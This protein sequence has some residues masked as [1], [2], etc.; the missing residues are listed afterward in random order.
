MNATAVASDPPSGSFSLEKAPPKVARRILCVEDND[1]DFGLFQ[2]HLKDSDLHPPPALQ[3]ARTLGEATSLIEKGQA[4]GNPFELV[5]LDL[6]LPDSAGEDTYFRVREQAP[7]A[8]IIVL[9]GMSDRGLALEM[10]QHGAQ[11]YV[12]KDALNGDL[13]GRSILYALERQRVKEGLVKLNEKLLQTTNDLKAAQDHL[14]QVEKLESL[15]RLA[16][17][18]AHEVKNPLGIIQMGVDYLKNKVGSLGPNAVT[19]LEHMEQAVTRADRIIWDMLDFSRSDSL[20]L[21]PCDANELAA[22]TLRMVN[23]ELNKRKIETEVDLMRPL[24]LILADQGKIE[25]VLINILVNAAQAMDSNGRLRLR[26]YHGQVEE[27]RRNEGLRAMERLRPGDEAVVIEVRDYGPGIPPEILGRIFEPF[28]TTKPTGQGT[29]LGLAV[30]RR[31]IELHS[32]YLQ[33]MN[34]ENPTGLRVRLVF[35]AEPATIETSAPHPQMV[36][37][38]AANP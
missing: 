5:V 29:G 33:V 36:G 17:G 3:R 7:Q 4:E 27:V 21:K 1:G 37:G 34:V 9:S 20:E 8:A 14:I 19:I 35:K 13:L 18:V 30:A 28:F 22:A 25:Q 16:A 26:T 10:V 38:T 6:S 2:I 31:I 12:P 24:P 15:G 32:G 11:D 23:H